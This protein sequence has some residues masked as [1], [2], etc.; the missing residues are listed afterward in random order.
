MPIGESRITRSGT[1]AE[2]R[3]AGR[4]GLPLRWLVASGA[5]DEAIRRSGQMRGTRS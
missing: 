1:P 2:A 5:F 3:G 4:D